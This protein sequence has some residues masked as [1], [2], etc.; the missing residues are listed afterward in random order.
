MSADGPA[1]PFEALRRTMV[2]NQLRTVAVDDPRVVAALGD[3]PREAFVPEA[4]R[5]IAYA[6]LAVPLGNGRALNTPMAT[7]RLINAAD[8]DAGE[9]ILIV[10]AATGYAAAVALRLGAQVTAVETSESLGDALRANVP[11]AGIV[12]GDLAAGAA[13]AAP[14]DA[15]VIDG[16]IEQVPQALIDQLAP[17]GRLV[18]GLVEDGVTRLAVGRRGGSGFGLTAFADADVVVLPGFAR[19]RAFV[20]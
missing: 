7:A 11:Q 9:K 3:V 15:I 6:D 2:L 16:A 10:G 19:P 20:F 14:F 12:I 8:I 5:D 4:R 13:A 17:G 1:D 18:T